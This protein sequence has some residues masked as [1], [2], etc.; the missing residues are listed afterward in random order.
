MYDY[1]LLLFCVSLFEGDFYNPFLDFVWN[2][3]LY[4]IHMKLKVMGLHLS[5]EV[6]QKFGRV[7]NCFWGAKFTT[8]VFEKF[9][10]MKF[11]N[12]IT[13]ILSFKTLFIK[14]KILVSCEI[15]V[16]SLCLNILICVKSYEKMQCKFFRY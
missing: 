12:I 3:H 14:A 5:M 4:V 6:F 11:C 1:F 8:N 13:T 2:P 9:V 15:F 10:F 7:K 16:K